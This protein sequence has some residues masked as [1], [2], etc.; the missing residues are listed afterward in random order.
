MTTINTT[1]VIVSVLILF[2]I[3]IF[4]YQFIYNKKINKMLHT[5]GRKPRL[6]EPL[7]FLQLFLF[8]SICIISAFLYVNNV[9]L[10]KEIIRKDDQIEQIRYN[11]IERNFPKSIMQYVYMNY[12]N[13]Y[14]GFHTSDLGYVICI[15][16]N[17]PQELIDL[18]ENSNT[19]WE[20]VLY[21]Y[22][23]LS[24]VM[25]ILR[26]DNTHFNIMTFFINYKTNS[27]E[28]SIHVGNT[29]DPRMQG[30]VDCGIITIEWTTGIIVAG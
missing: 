10:N 1:I 14:G 5:R 7:Q 29:I 3:L 9:V 16:E 12:N 27:V 11:E 24:T 21:S 8:I 25:D 22:S 30:Y 6:I 20:Y 4:V 2:S 15:K 17:S 23:E 26:A 13:F 18:I 28:V 19:L